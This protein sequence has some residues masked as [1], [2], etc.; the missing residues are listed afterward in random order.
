MNNIRK[1]IYNHILTQVSERKLFPNDRVPTEVKLAEQF[2]TNRM[3]AHLAVKMLEKEGIVQRNKRQG[4]FINKD[5]P[6][7]TILKLKNLSTN[8]VHVIASFS[9]FQN[10]HWN[11]ASLRELESILNSN[12]YKVFYKE[13]PARLTRDSFQKI[14]SETKE[15]GSCAIVIFPDKGESIFLRDNLDIIFNYQREIYLFDRGSVLLDKW[16]FHS[17]RLDPFGEGVMVGKYLYEH[18]HRNILFLEQDSKDKRYWVEEREKGLRFGLDLISKGKIKPDIWRFSR[19]SMYQ[20]TC[21]RIIKSK[22]KFTVV[23]PN[24]HFA[25]WLIEAAETKVCIANIYTVTLSSIKLFFSCLL[26]TIDSYIRFKW[27]HL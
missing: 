11:E 4:T 3:N 15:V 1:K 23:T 26:H 20:K 7:K 6:S 13:L 8:R 25:V 5:I 9:K 27:S 12:S 21:Q 18:G 14:L 17:I 24:D 10:I 22:E 19:E 16:P 2:H